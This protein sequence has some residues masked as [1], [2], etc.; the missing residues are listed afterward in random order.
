MATDFQ[1][2]RDNEKELWAE[3]LAR[4]LDLLQKKTK[5]PVI[6]IEARPESSLSLTASKFG[7]AP[8]L[9][10]GAEPPT[11]SEDKYLRLLAQFNCAELPQNP[12]LPE[13]GILQFWIDHNEEILYNAELQE[14]GNVASADGDNSYVVYYPK[15]RDCYSAAELSE[16]FLA[17]VSEST[18]IDFPVFT[19]MALKFELGEQ[20]I[21]PSDGG[22]EE[23]FVEIWNEEYPEQKIY[24]L[25]DLPESITESIWECDGDFHQLGGNPIFACEDPRNRV[26][27]EEYNRLLLQIDSQWDE[28][29]QQY[30]INWG[31][32]GVG[33]FFISEKKLAKQDFDDVLYNWDSTE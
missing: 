31:A 5:L 12:I 23:L 7:G 8:Y 19:Q 14:F 17:Q 16:Q 13:E 33:N 29:Q 15:I 28:S 25:A 22:F 24:E 21:M 20:G 11:N 26:E 32:A 3:Q 9:P 6:K 4:V 18:D 27:F 1:E 30:L 2:S 10:Y